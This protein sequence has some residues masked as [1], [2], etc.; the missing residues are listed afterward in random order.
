M[1]GL[2]GSHSQR[3]HDQRLALILCSEAMRGE[4]AGTGEVST[5]GRAPHSIDWRIRYIWGAH[6][7]VTWRCCDAT[8]DVSGKARLGRDDGAGGPARALWLALLPFWPRGLF[9]T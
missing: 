2:R 7:I 8:D 1:S 5:Q 3:R 9:R 4:P 6:S